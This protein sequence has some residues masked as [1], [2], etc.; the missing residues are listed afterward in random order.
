[1]KK[2]ILINV[3]IVVSFIMFT[4]PVFAI[5]YGKKVY[6][7]YYKEDGYYDRSLTYTNLKLHMMNLGYNVIGYNSQGNGQIEN[8]LKEGI[9]LFVHDHGDPGIQYLGASKTGIS[10]N[11]QT[12]ELKAVSKMSGNSV[13]KMGIAV[14]FGCYTGVTGYNGDLAQETVNKFA[15]SSIMWSSETNINHVNK[16]ADAFG[17]KAKKYNPTAAETI[18]YADNAVRSYYGSQADY[19]VNNKVERGNFSW[20]WGDL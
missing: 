12:D 19:I 5:D 4:M 14:Y 11:T 13:K 6:V 8:Q 9:A 20:R 3:F 10:G 18:R 16:W 1:M 17:E 15:K 2:K 7:H